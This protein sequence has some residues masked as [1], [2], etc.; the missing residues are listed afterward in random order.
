MKTAVYLSGPMTGIEDYNR[1][2]FYEAEEKLA[3]LGFCVFN[4]A[5]KE[6]V[7]AKTWG[8]YIGEDLDT[9]DLMDERYNGQC[10]LVLLDGFEGSRGARHETLHAQ[11]LHWEIAGLKHFLRE[12]KRNGIFALAENLDT[13]NAADAADD[14]ANPDDSTGSESVTIQETLDRR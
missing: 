7:P 4:P 12:A 5:R 8:E 3:A 6:V 14:C 9:M 13:F 10:V 2:A 11:I 1:E